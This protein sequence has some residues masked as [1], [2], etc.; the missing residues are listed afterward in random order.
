M[1][2]FEEIAQ[3][4]ERIKTLWKSSQNKMHAKLLSNLIWTNVCESNFGRK[5]N[6]IFL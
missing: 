2:A 3:V 5:F 1:K 4:A 6:C